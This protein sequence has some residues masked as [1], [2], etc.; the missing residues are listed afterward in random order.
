MDH[1]DAIALG[2]PSVGMLRP[3]HDFFIAL[4]GNQGVREP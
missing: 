3:R 1:L 2:K 4:D